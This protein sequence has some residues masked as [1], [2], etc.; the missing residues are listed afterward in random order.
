MP[1]MKLLIVWQFGMAKNC[2]YLH[3]RASA[4]LGTPC[5]SLKVIKRPHPLDGGN[6]IT[7][8]LLAGSRTGFNKQSRGLAKYLESWSL[9]FT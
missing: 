1:N 7:L 8:V 5:N 4:L 6:K 3:F 2:C 9:I